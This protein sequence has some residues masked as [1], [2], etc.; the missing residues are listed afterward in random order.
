MS[1]SPVIQGAG[2]AQVLRPGRDQGA[3]L[4][5]IGVDDRAGRVRRIWAPAA[6]AKSIVMNS[7]GARWI[8]RAAAITSWKE[9][10][11]PAWKKEATGGDPQPK[12]GRF[13]GDSICSTTHYGAGNVELPTLVCADGKRPS[14]ARAKEVL[15]LVG[16]GE[17]DGPFSVAS[18]PAGSSSVWRLQGRWVNKRQSCWP[19]SHGETDSRTFRGRSCNIFPGPE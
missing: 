6:A 16:L 7:C 17:K 13:S 5:G 12:L 11:F 8:S 10:T 15:E 4:R 18:F 1:G 2:R 3:C 9:T 19:T 14:Q